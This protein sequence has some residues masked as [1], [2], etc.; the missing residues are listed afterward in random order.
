MTRRTKKVLDIHVQFN[1]YFPQA[2]A[3]GA[4]SRLILR[5]WLKKCIVAMKMI[6]LPIVLFLMYA[7]NVQGPA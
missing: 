5:D 2:H 3:V 1:K 4:V 6:D 7:T